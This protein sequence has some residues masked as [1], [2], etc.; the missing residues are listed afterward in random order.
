MGAALTVIALA[1]L[2]PGDPGRGGWQA[3][4]PTAA[5]LLV[6]VLLFVPLGLTLR[7]RRTP[8][9]QVFLA[10]LALATAIEV[11][12]L[13]VV[14][15]RVSS[16]WDIGANLAGAWGAMM[17][18]LLAL[19]LPLAAGWVATTFLLA[20]A[21]PPSLRWWGQWAHHFGGT[22]PFDGRILALEFNGTPAPDRQLSPA[23][24]T[25]MRARFADSG[26]TLRVKFL[27]GPA[28]DALVHLATVADGEGGQVAGFWQ[29]GP[30]LEVAWHAKGTDLGLRTP[31]IRAEG[32]LAGLPDTSLI[33]SA[34]IG[35]GHWFVALEGPGYERRTGRILGPWQGWRLLWPQAPPPERLAW[36]LC[37]AWTFACLGPLTG[38]VVHRARRWRAS[39]IP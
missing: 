34:W 9:V 18:P 11:A 36:L 21:A 6:N 33:A 17:L 28:G 19:A 2:V 3:A 30:G 15:G 29:R 26:V 38:V 20:P 32:F 10:A 22:V 14:P 25:S 16:P 39:P 8:A 31:A 12:Q 35:N 13:L 5:D 27:A 23:A 7:L 4:L 24:T 1:T 37:A